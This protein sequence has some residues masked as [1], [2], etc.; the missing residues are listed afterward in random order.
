MVE[1][2][3]LFY[4]WATLLSCSSFS[5]FVIDLVGDRYH[6]HSHRIRNDLSHVHKGLFHK[7]MTRFSLQKKLYGKGYGKD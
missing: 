6:L 4:Y 3:A 2:M 5:Y 1:Q 7:G